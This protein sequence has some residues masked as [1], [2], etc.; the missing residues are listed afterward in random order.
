MST[1]REISI[2]STLPA[3]PANILI[4]D[5]DKKGHVPLIKS[6]M[7]MKLRM[8]KHTAWQTV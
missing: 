3:A 5:L 1:H 8:T 7:I 6:V 4:N 2:E